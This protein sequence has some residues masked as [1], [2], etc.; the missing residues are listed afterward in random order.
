MTYQQFLQIIPSEPILIAGC[1][2]GYDIFTGLPIYFSLLEL[3]IPIYLAS[4]SFTKIELLDKHQ[5]LSDNIYLITPGQEIS[6]S[7]YFPEQLL[8]N[9]L[10]IP[11]IAFAY[12]GGVVTLEKSYRDIIKLYNIKTIILAD[13][14]C[15]SILFG[16]EEEL[17]TP[18][19][20]MM[21]IFVVNKL[22]KDNI[23]NLA[24]LSILGITADYHSV[25]P[26][27]VK[28]NI[29]YLK[30]NGALVMEYRLNNRCDISKRYVDVVLACQIDKSIVNCSILEAINNNFGDII[31]HY[32]RNRL[33]ENKI[34]IAPITSNNYIF[35]LSVVADSV[36]YLGL[37][38]GVDDSDEI[39]QIILEYN[40]NILK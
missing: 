2:G 11:I 36:K 23:I 32:L 25:N 34:F 35:K 24:Y 27:D 40:K 26:V 20:D 17:A 33:G 1:G 28:N 5:K 4:F 15:D 9:K 29:D 10:N 8:A 12:V 14:G 18:V 21:N 22:L 37:L 19:E 16:T 13:G 30:N 39:D 38:D 31:S 7:V 3:N 6:E